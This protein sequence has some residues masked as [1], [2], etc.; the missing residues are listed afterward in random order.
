MKLLKILRQSTRALLANKV[1][2]FL[3][4]LGIIIGIGSVIG[5]VS[6]G[7]GVQ[8][9]IS[10]QISS[11]GSK[12]ITVT[13]GE[14]FGA[15]L[16]NPS[17]SQNRAATGVSGNPQT[18]TED[19]L[20]AFE[21]ISDPSISKVAGTVSGSSIFNIKGVDKRRSVIGV[22]PEFFDIYSYSVNTGRL[23]TDEDDNDQADFVILG[24]DLANDLFGTTN[25]LD[26]TI[27]IAETEFTVIGVLEEQASS[28]F[29]NP[30]NQGYIPDQ[31][32]LKIFKSSNYNTFIAQATSEDFVDQAKSKIEETL[33]ASHNISD[34]SLADFSVLTAKD[35]LS[36]I[37]QITGILTALLAGI[38]A[39]SLLVG[40][41]GIMN[42]M[43][44]SVTERTR[45]IGLRK[46]VGATTG[47]IMVQFII[48]SILLTLL[49]GVFGIGLGYMIGFIVNKLTSQIIPVITPETI[50]L[51]VGVSSLIGIIF[52]VYPAAKA[53]RLNPIDALRYE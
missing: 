53:A 20:T 2:S 30:N 44:V 1:R 40:G 10:K 47:D 19:D 24:N 21:N 8:N 26:K 48:E 43:L 11:L 14:G 15:A 34:K 51:A 3:T 9:G 12:N 42:I 46:A 50:L 16:N 23:I 7:S 31:T 17:Q 18:L 52:G 29:S 45:E 22:T 39:I 41:I 49:G 4:V 35:L 33:L 25:A 38:A 28:N 36:T 32:A 13:P 37:N 27:T 5:L 6:L